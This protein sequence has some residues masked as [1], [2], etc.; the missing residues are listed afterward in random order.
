MR[1]L[2]RFLISLR[3]AIVL[4][5]LLCLLSMLGTLIPQGREDGDYLAAYPRA[6]QTI[7]D[8]GFDDLYHGRPFHA[9]LALLAISSVLCT[10]TRLKLTRARLGSRLVL[11]MPAEIASMP[12]RGD[13]PAEKPLPGDGDWQRRKLDDEGE[14][15]LR[16]HGR[17]SLIGGV[18]I[19]VGFVAILAGGLW[20]AVSGV[21]MSVRGMAGETAVVPPVDAIR[22]AAAADRLRRAAR[23]IQ[24]QNPHDPRLETIRHDVETMDTT[25]QAG[26]A[27]PAC[28]VKFEDLWVDYHEASKTGNEPIVKSWN[29]RVTLTGTGHEPASGVV[30]VNQPLTWGDFTFYQADWS[31]KYQK[32]SV[33]VL[34]AVAT[35]SDAGLVATMTL[36][37]GKPFKPGWSNYTFVLIDFM[38]DFR[39]MGEQ[40]VSVSDELRNPGGRI[41]AYGSDGKV[42]GRAWAFSHEMAE[43]SGH[44]SNLPYRFEVVSADPVYESGFQ[45][46]HDPGVPVVWAGCL[47]MT[48]GLFLTFYIMYYEEWL[49]RR[50]DG[51][52]MA[53]VA[54]NR[55]AVVLKTVLESLC[56]A[57][58]ASAPATEP[59]PEE[60]I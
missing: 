42:A 35:G 17:A 20:G 43:L 22:V 28:R 7:L 30:R 55:P 26:M 38:S 33:Q 52:V 54:G 16:V 12:V 8:L 18:L 1:P 34:R 57:P 21:E 2:F 59:P 10:V 23:A 41:V 4:I 40:F 15:L 14:L 51:R 29:S 39:I 36:E 37:I 27:S 32:V 5:G 48:L 58:G 60:R 25:F 19:H 53:A 11:A 50:P 44:T 47:L 45:V 6:G 31:K 24:V 56:A 3:T 9:L 46:S 13:W 49:W